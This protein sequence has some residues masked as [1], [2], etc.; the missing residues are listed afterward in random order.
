[1]WKRFADLYLHCSKWIPR[2]PRSPRSSSPHSLHLLETRLLSTPHWDK[3]EIICTFHILLGFFVTAAH[4][5]AAHREPQAREK[6]VESTEKA[7]DMLF[8]TVLS[9]KPG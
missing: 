7:L 3:E 8:P 1:M 6:T 4:N 5:T 2:S 9:P